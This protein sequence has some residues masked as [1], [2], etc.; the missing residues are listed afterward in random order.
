MMSIFHLAIPT[1]N[2]QESKDFYAGI[3]DL[4]VGREYPEYVIFDFFGHQLVCHL[5]PEKV[6]DCVEDMYPRHFG[7]ILPTI[8]K[9]QA[10]YQ[11]AKE[12]GAT[13]YKD[14]FERHKEKSGWHAA[15]FLVD[16]SNNLVEFKYYYDTESILLG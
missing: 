2:L 6:D 13:V 14:M 16:P 12:R 1:K 5:A 15:F 8:E 4:G 7:L 3:L 10:V 11:R 9:L